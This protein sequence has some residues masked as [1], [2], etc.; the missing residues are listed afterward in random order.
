[1]LLLTLWSR[2][3]KEFR[4]TTPINKVCGKVH[5]Y[6]G[7]LLDFSK[8]GKVVLNMSDYVHTVLNDAPGYMS[9]TMGT[10]ASSFLFQTNK[11][12]RKLG[13]QDAE[14]FVHLVLQLLYLSQRGRPDIRTA[15]AFLCT[16]LQNPDE[17]DMKKVGQVI[18]YLRGMADMTLTLSGDQ[19]GKIQWWVDASYAVHSD[20]KDHTGGTMSMGQGSIY[21]VS[22][23]QE[24]VSR[25]STESEIIG[26]YD[27]L[28]KVLWTSYFLQGQGFHVGSTIIYQDNNSSILLAKHG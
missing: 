11:G 28:P 7:M 14:M 26:V 18:K 17:D 10:P 5:H 4:A 27:V 24:M 23:K 20:M 6:L 9:G 3:K 15:V 16:R 8:P 2:W 19:S 1:M 13:K 22:N 12:C 21:S 25:S